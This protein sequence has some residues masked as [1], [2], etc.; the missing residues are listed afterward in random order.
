MYYLIC[1]FYYAN[2]YIPEHRVDLKYCMKSNF[3]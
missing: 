1:F 2:I 3:L